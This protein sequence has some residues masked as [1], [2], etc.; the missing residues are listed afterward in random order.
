MVI[1]SLVGALAGEEGTLR[2]NS[3]HGEQYTGRSCL[4]WKG[5]VVDVPHSAQMT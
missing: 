1:G 5:T 4:G 3:K 2:R